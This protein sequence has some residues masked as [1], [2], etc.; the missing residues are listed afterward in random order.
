MDERQS[1]LLLA[2]RQITEAV[3]GEQSLDKAMNILVQQIRRATHADCCSLYIY[4]ALRDRFRLRATDGLAQEAVGKA[5]LK[6]GEGLVGVVGKRREMLDLADAFSHPNFK[7][8]PDVGEDEYHSFLGVPVLNQ[9]DLLGVLVIQS[10]E[11][12]QFGPNEEYFMLTLS[13]QIASVIAMSRSVELDEEQN[14]QRIHGLSG[15]GGL[16]IARAM[17][18]QPSVSLDQVKILHSDDPVMQTELFHQAMFQLQ[19]EMDRASL[20]MQEDDKSNA[21]FGYMS[22][23]GQLLDDPTFQEDVDALIVDQGLLASSAVKLVIEKRLAE[24]ERKHDKEEYVDTQDFAQVLITRLVHDSA[25]DFEL[26]ERVI[27]VVDSLPAAMVAELPRDKIAGFVA[28][29]FN[30]SAHTLILARDLGIPAVLGVSAD[31]SAIDGHMLILDGRHSEILLDPPQSVVDEFSELLSQDKKQSDLFSS[32]LDKE[33]V[34][35]DGERIQIQLNAGLNHQDSD[36][37]REI[38]DGIGLYRTE[39]AFMLTQTFPTEDQQEEWYSTLLTQFA[40]KP[41]CMRTLDVGSDKSLPYLPIKEVNPAFG[42]RG[43]RVTID[44]PQILRTQLRA[45]LRAQQ[46]CGNLEIMV[47]MVS[48]PDEIYFVKNLLLKEAA[49]IREE[50]GQSFPLPRFGVMVEVPSLV[51]ILD[52]IINDIDFLSIGSNDLIQYLLA[53]DRSNSRVSRFYDPFHP[54]VVRCLA[55]LSEKAVQ[56]GKRISVCGELAGSAM[57]AL[58]LVSLGY[59]YLSMNYSD[60]AQVKYILRHV[61]AKELQD[62]K[63]KALSLSDPQSIRDLYVE[64]AR[65]NG[66]SRAMDFSEAQKKAYQ[67]EPAALPEI[68]EHSGRSKQS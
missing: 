19:V 56:Y 29:S 24:A 41:V 67:V 12:R 46:R 17:V 4:E 2:L 3:A 34:C 27:L 7:Y 68:E 42:W 44:N 23:Y 59:K 45:M 48:R 26:N 66:L 55:Y 64:F 13:V 22:G 31:L 9:G 61:S 32:E 33:G 58:L 5:T 8:L 18:W 65:A 14:I 28:T 52:D 6:S 20:K 36:K 39:I 54:A 10:K 57:G 62:L 60:L 16:A 50:S 49:A 30:T 51:Y 15:T 43:V 11:Q 47:P 1:E 53:V 35:L 25:R 21:L 37:L 63:G 38:T 40:G